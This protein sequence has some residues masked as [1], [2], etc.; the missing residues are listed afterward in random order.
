M[1]QTA[2]YPPLQGSQ[3]KARVAPRPAPAICSHIIQRL[4]ESAVEDSN[5]LQDIL[6]K[7]LRLI[8]GRH[9]F[10]VIEFGQ[11]RFFLIENPLD[12]R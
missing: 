5:F 7:L 4:G 11:P 8:M 12:G 1:R 3:P 10:L 9:P 2:L 6:E